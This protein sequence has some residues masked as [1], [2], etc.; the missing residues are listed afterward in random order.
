MAAVRL[1]LSSASGS[2]GLCVNS[3][4]DAEVSTHP[5]SRHVPLRIPYR[6]NM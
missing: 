3:S 2:F 4:A 1:F 6:T 5:A